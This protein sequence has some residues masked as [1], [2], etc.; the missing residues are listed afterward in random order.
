MKGPSLNEHTRRL[1]FG[2]LTCIALLGAE[3]RP[4]IA[5]STLLLAPD[6]DEAKRPPAECTATVDGA[7]SC[8]LVELRDCLVLIDG[9]L[10]AAVVRCGLSEAGVHETDVEY[11]LITHGDTDHI[12]GL[13]DEDLALVCPNATYVLHRQLWEAWVSDGRRGDPTPFYDE[14]QQRIARSLAQRIEGRVALLDGDG[15]VAPGIRG[16]GTPGHRPSHL[17]YELSTP[18]G[19][20]LHAGDALIAPIFIAQ[21]TRGTAFDTDPELGIRSR[22]ALLKRAAQ[23]KTLT[24]VPHFP[25]PGFVRIVE[26]GEGFACR[27]P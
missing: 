22:L 7:H 23:P 25:F 6:G 21:P 2:G 8:L 5:L 27:T 19:R 16:L 12:A 18:E 1:E 14:A 9:S 20:L 24:Y 10:D 3:Q 15:E 11:V 13:L 17:S 26:Q 4:R